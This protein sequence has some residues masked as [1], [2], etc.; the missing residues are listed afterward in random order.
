[1]VIQNHPKL[2]FSDSLPPDTGKRAEIVGKTDYLVNLCECIDI[3]R[4]LSLV[5]PFYP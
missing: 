3:F 5:L 1:M 4:I 2:G